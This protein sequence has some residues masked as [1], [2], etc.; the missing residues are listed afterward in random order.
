M[1]L[2]II[3]QIAL[4][5]HKVPQTIAAQWVDGFLKF[6]T[7]LQQRHPKS[8]EITTNHGKLKGLKKQEKIPQS[9]AA[10]R[11]FHGGR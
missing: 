9:L 10:Q 5:K 6:A 4:K 1:L 11:D 2:G 7:L 3:P 8:P